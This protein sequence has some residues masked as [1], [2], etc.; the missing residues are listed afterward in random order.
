[1]KLSSTI[2]ITI[3]AILGS[4]C[5]GWLSSYQ[6]KPLVFIALMVIGLVVLT[7]IRD[8][9]LIFFTIGIHFD[10]LFVDLGFAKVGYGDFVL[11]LLLFYWLLWR[12]NGRS[13]LQTAEKW[14]LLIIYLIGVGLSWQQ[15]PTPHLE[16][17]QYIRHC[18]YLLGYFA[19]TDLIRERRQIHVFVWCTLLVVCVH[20][21]IALFFFNESLRL[22]GL[23]GQPNIFGGLIGP[24]A[25]IA[26][27]LSSSSL[28]KPA[29]RLA[30]LLAG[31]VICTALI[32]T[33]S[34]G[35]QLAF[36]LTILWSFRTQWKRIFTIGFLSL[37]IL[38]LILIAYPD[39]LDYFFNRWDLKDGSVTDRQSILLNGL[40][41]IFKYPFFGIGFGQFDKL[42]EVI[43]LDKGHGRASHNNYLGSLATLGIPTASILFYFI[44]YQ[45]RRLWRLSDLKVE[46]D[47]VYI[48]ILQA[49]FI[50][51][52]VTLVFR[53]GRR[54]ISWSF[55]AMYSIAVIIYHRSARQSPQ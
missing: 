55:L 15:G 19:L 43:S 25:L 28:F 32:L 5:I 20:V 37:I 45:A 7:Q 1:M 29:L 42:G 31:L 23:P 3:A 41:A 51:Q 22:Q 30:L 18:S 4:I 21:I 12:F 40:Q 16:T 11:A 24:G 26:I 17:G 6:P 33:V 53:G 38:Q 14:P 27:L 34:R 10:D 13:P 46:K 8:L 47:R 49:L 9:W 48:G 2:S 36:V 35:A 44:L 50:F 39:R 54:M 52:S